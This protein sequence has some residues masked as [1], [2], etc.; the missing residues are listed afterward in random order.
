[1]AYL[2]GSEATYVTGASLSIDGGF[3]ARQ[4]KQPP[5]AGKG[6]GSGYEEKSWTEVI[7]TAFSRDV[8]YVRTLGADRVIDVHSGKFEERVKD[9]DVVIDT[10][11]GETLDRSFEVI[12]SGGVLLSSVAMPD[13]A[14]AA[15]HRIR[16]VFFLVAVTSNGLSEIAGLLDSGQLTTNVGEVLPLAEAR[17]AHA[18]LAGKPHKRGKIVLAV[19]GWLSA[20]KSA[21]LWVQSR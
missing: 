1:V 2:A 7:A 13:Q 12:K 11:G 3:T 18:M 9:A 10:I 8:D 21:K 5:P 16:G 20:A 17:L 6:G 19:D 15:R 4:W 14:K